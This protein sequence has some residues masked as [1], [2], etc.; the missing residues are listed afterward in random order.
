MTKEIYTA[1]I[2]AERDMMLTV[3]AVEAIAEGVVAIDLVR[4]DKGPMPPWQ[5]GAHLEIDVPEIGVRHYS[6]CGDPKDRRSWRIAI[7]LSDTSTAQASLFFH[8]KTCVGDEFH[9]FGPRNNFPFALPDLGRSVHFIAGGI[10]IT[11]IFPMVVAAADAGADWSL[12]YYGR[13]L[14]SMAFHDR[15]SGYGDKV[16]FIPHGSRAGVSVDSIL[17]STSPGSLTYTCGPAALIS[18]VAEVS[19]RRGLLHKS[20][21]FSYSGEN[22][23][24]DDDRPFKLVCR[25]SS[26]T[27][28]VAA[29]ETIVEALEKSGTPTRTS[30]RIGICGTCETRVLAGT[31]DHRDSLLSEEER[32]RGESMMICVGRAIGDEL[33]LD[34]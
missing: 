18:D 24:R 11:A 13:S 5:P 15:L 34:I 9:V 17:S 22:G 3:S 10:G 2:Y 14:E 23:Q 26:R 4:S 29:S 7:R 25:A 8:K 6:L 16:R 28:D 21:L 12:T 1:G 31:P 27:V 33:V 19:S 20:E 32:S 30:C